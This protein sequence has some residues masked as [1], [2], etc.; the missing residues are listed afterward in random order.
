VRDSVKSIEKVHKQHL[1]QAQQFAELKK[2]HEAVKARLADVQLQAEHKDVD[3][4][5]N[6]DVKL[7]QT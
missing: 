5:N 2:S 6:L 3:A 1:V 7:K 4:T